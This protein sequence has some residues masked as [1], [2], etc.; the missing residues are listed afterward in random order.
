MSLF[1]FRF[2]R[3]SFSVPVVRVGFFRRGLGLM[4][5]TRETSNLLFAFR[6]PCRVAITAWLVFFPFLAV[7]CD[8]KGRVVDS[9]RITPFTLS[10]RPRVSASYL[11]ELPLNRR[12]SRIT[13][14]IVGK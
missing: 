12:N 4:C 7:W 2:K 3:R 10:V 5:R 9:R 8:S 14:F 1:R 11:L 6:R 13:R